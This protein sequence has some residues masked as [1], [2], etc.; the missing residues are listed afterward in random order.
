[1]KLFLVALSYMLLAVS[2]RAQTHS[3]TC[4]DS[5]ISSE[6]YSVSLVRLI[7]TPEKYHGKWVQVVGYLNLEFEG[8]AIFL[9]Q[10]DYETANLKNGIWVN[11]PKDLKTKLSLQDYSKH[12][13]IMS[14]CFDMNSTGH[15]GMFGGELNNIN[16]LDLWRTR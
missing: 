4:N 14:G 8:N 1:M 3:V 6:D 16:R 7:A 2:L 13:V 12:Y 10:E 11:V 9:H 5:V 15:F